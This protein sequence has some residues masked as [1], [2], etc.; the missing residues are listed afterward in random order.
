MVKNNFQPGL[1]EPT[2]NDDETK[3]YSIGSQWVNSFFFVCV[4]ATAGAA[5]WNKYLKAS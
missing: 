2:V 3:G 4:D 1:G 5:V